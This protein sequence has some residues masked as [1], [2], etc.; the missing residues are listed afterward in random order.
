MRP[1]V[2]NG[3][4]GDSAAG[5]RSQRRGLDTRE[6]VLAAAA[7]EFTANGVAGAR[8][9]RIAADAQA[10]KERIYA[11]Y[12]D[13]ET[14]FNHVMQRGLDTIAEAV[15]IDVD[16]VDYTVRLHDYFTEHPDSHRV[17][18]W[19]WM[20]AGRDTEL[21]LRLPAYRHKV[22]TIARAQREG[23][24]DAMW[25]PHGLLALLLSIATSWL[26][27]APEI[28]ALS[29]EAGRAARALRRAEVARAAERIIRPSN[30]EDRPTG[31]AP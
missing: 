28:H 10:S 25:E 29:P 27:A 12:G 16:L 23:L 3:G 26:M 31:E 15:P 6:R 13:K 9:N 21:S 17:A 20:D 24:A 19:A 11:W 22:D 2:Q 8:I 1:I 14:L 7:A 4:M 30:S 5:T 18:T